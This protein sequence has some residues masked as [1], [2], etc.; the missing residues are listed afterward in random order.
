MKFSRHIAAVMSISVALLLTSLPLSAK[1]LFETN[2]N[3]ISYSPGFENGTNGWYTSGGQIIEVASAPEGTHCAFLPDSTSAQN[4]RSRKYTVS[5]GKDYQLRFSYITSSGADGNPQ[6]RFRFF[7]GGTF[8]GESVQSLS[9]TDGQWETMYVTGICPYYASSFDVF[10]TTNTFGTFSGSVAIDNTQVYAHKDFDYSK[11][12]SPADGSKGWPTKLT[13]RWPQNDQAY[14]Y[15]V[16]TGTDY[17]EVNNANIDVMP[18]DFDIDTKVNIRDFAL[19]AVQW[20]KNVSNVSG[21]KADTNNDNLIDVFDLGN[22]AAYFAQ[23]NDIPDSYL[24]RC[25]SAEM[26]VTMPETNQ[27]YYWRVDTL[28][29]G[30]V[31]KGTTM[32]FNCEDYLDYNIAAPQHIYSIDNSDL[33]RTQQVLFQSLQGLI[34]R[35]RPELFIRNNANSMWLTDFVNTYGITHTNID[36]VAGSITPLRWVLDHYDDKYDSYILCDAWNDSNS[37]TAAV[38]LAASLDRTIVVDTSDLALMAGRGKTRVAD[39]RGKNEKNVWDAKKDTYNKNAIFVQ[40]DAIGGHGANLRDMPIAIKAFTWWYNDLDAT[41]EVFDAY[42]KNIP[43]YGWDSPVMAGEG[44]AVKYHS[45]HSMYSLVTDWSLNLSLYA[46]MAN[47]EPEIEFS[48]PCS[49]NEYTPEDNVHYVTFILSDMDNANTI[50]DVAGWIDNTNRYSNQYRGKFAMGWGM[51]PVMTKLG[52]SVM[53]WW[54]DNATEKDCFV[55]YCSG[56][57]YFNPS[58]FPDM[59]IHAA[60][61]E[62]YLEKAD[63]KNLAIIDSVMPAKPLSD[64]YYETA[65][66]FTRIKRL[67]GMFYLEYMQYAMHGGEI[68]WFDGKPMVTARFDYRDNIFYSN[69]K[70]TA[71]DLAASINAMPATPNNENGYTFVTVHAWSRGWNDVADC[72]RLLDSDVRVVTPDEMIEQLYLHNVGQ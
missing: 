66:W 26:Q 23:A 37:L 64:D 22:V 14:A 9:L 11:P 59:D 70:A 67:R 28:V 56:M 6:L 40:R 58:H 15:L 72:I 8:M 43:C 13:F 51:P 71:S 41:S 47:Y 17:N 25:F 44:S 21:F 2:N 12:Y 35:E 38:S 30:E 42:N 10:F 27:D 54:Y 34:A 55:A 53:K 68:F 32:F 50:F 65:K 36:N 57:D 60:H 29:N 16:Y 4:W 5:S 31:Q 24:A 69:V 18:A 39:S 63:I 46:G 62:Q 3:L 48:Q 1:E 61:L 19:L 52:P 20:Q 33:S 49:D 45:E 7:S